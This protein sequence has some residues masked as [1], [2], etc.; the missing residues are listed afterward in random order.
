[1]KIFLE[2]YKHKAAVQFLAQWLRDAE[3]GKDEGNVCRCMQFCWEKSYGV[4]EEMIFYENSHP[5]LCWF[6]PSP[7]GKFLFKPDIVVFSDGIPEIIFEVVHK[8]PVDNY[9]IEV[10]KNFYG[11]YSVSLFQVK[12]DKILNK[13]QVPIILDFVQ[14]I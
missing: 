9:K 11:D 1:M 13:T 6:E 8:H 2:S 12:A 10:I 3:A 4:V 7:K 5:S 14:L